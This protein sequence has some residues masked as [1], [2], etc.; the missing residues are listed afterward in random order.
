MPKRPDGLVHKIHHIQKL[1]STFSFHHLRSNFSF[2]SNPVE[3]W[4]HILK[5]TWKDRPSTTRLSPLI[6]TL[7]PFGVGSWWLLASTR[8]DHFPLVPTRWFRKENLERNWLCRFLI[9]EMFF[10][11]NSCA[12]W[13]WTVKLH[14]SIHLVFLCAFF[15]LFSRDF[16]HLLSNQK[17]LGNNGDAIRPPHTPS[18]HEVENIRTSKQSPHCKSSNFS[19]LRLVKSAHAE[20]SAQRNFTSALQKKKPLITMWSLV[21]SSILPPKKETADFRCEKKL[22]ISRTLRKL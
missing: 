2:V 19:A 6:S 20:K 3:P 16:Y 4:K 9:K 8:F 7:S 18:P 11:N 21:F 5:V 13:V 1:S 10:D 15:M 12:R 17:I 22:L 14:Q